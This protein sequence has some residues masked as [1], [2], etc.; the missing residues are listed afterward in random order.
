MDAQPEEP[1]RERSVHPSSYADGLDSNPR[2]GPDASHTLALAPGSG[3]ERAGPHTSDRLT[4]LDHDASSES[5]FEPQATTDDPL[6]D[7]APLVLAPG[8]VM[9]STRFRLRGTRGEGAMGI[10]YEAEHVE[11][12]RRVALKILRWNAAKTP[13]ARERFREEARMTTRIDSPYVVEVLDFG[14]LPDGRAFYAMEFLDGRSLA[15]ELAAEGVLPPHRVIG[16]LRQLCKGLAAAHRQGVIHRDVKPENVIVVRE[17]GR[18]VAKLVDFGVAIETQTELQGMTAGTPHYMAPEQV[19]GQPCDGRLDMYAL[20]CCAYELSSGEP[21]FNAGSVDQILRDQIDRD[22]MPL[23]VRRPEVPPALE[24]VIMRCLAKDPDD[25]YADMDDLEAALCEAQLASGLETD[26]DDLPLPDVDDLRRRQLAEFLPRTHVL[27]RRRWGTRIGALASTAVGCVLLLASLRGRATSTEPRAAERP[28]PR[29]TPAVPA[30]SQGSTHA[31]SS[32]VPALP[33]PE[34][35][36]DAWR[37]VTETRTT[38]APKRSRTAILDASD[39]SRTTVEPSTRPSARD[40]ARARALIRQGEA[41]LAKG[42]RSRAADMFRAALEVDP[43]AADA[44]GGLSDVYF[45]RGE[46][47]RALHYARLAVK[48]APRDGGHRIRLGDAYYKALRYDD[49]RNEYERAAALGRRDARA[50]LQKLS[51]RGSR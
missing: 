26:W 23:R 41:A 34:L 37:S 10:V 46:H 47:D 42:H 5:F 48:A 43:G 38:A 4:R 1:T 19:A 44:L 35:L 7:D 18:E 2:A 11:I 51:A 40:R 13:M 3:E 50:R 16:L 27:R 6:G 12:G 17:H 20:G 45:D 28:S 39:G 36:A 8:V 21:P 24:R 32:P 29:H 25:R 22:P 49:A 31:S 15:S 9:P 30:T 33:S 14:F